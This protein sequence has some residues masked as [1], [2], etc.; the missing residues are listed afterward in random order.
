[1]SDL[2]ALAET[3][4]SEPLSNT[5]GGNLAGDMNSAMAEARQMLAE[6][7]RRQDSWQTASNLV[8]KFNPVPGVLWPVVRGVFSGSQ[9]GK[10]GQ[11][12]F[13]SMAPLLHAALP[14]KTL[15]KKAA[16]TLTDSSKEP[17]L[18]QTIDLLGIEVA[19]AL[20]FMH[21]VSRRASS[22]VPEKVSRPILDDALLRAQIGYLV[23]E[24]YS[25]FGVG[26]GMLAG[27]AGRCGLAI[28]IALGTPEQVRQTLEAL[29]AGIEM[30]EVGLRVFGCDP[31]QVAAMALAAGGLSRDA[32]IGVAAFSLTDGESRASEESFLWLSAFSIIEEIRMGRSSEIKSRYWRALGIDASG[33]ETIKREAT[34]LLRRGHSW[35]WIVSSKLQDKDEEAEDAKAEATEP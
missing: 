35:G 26:R 28:Q 10:G 19:A 33:Q 16:T 29:A 13:W 31:L 22:S 12:A 18:T 32:A 15:G 5:S 8:A 7:D 30:N 11:M 25:E 6:A 2:A 20:C 1:M 27:F 17:S 21:S 9:L 23:G 3:A 4:K 24:H 34:T 14:D